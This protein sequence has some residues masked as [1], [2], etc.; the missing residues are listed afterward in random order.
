MASF[1]LGMVIFAALIVA[2]VYLF[3]IQ[4]SSIIEKWA[5]GLSNGGHFPKKADVHGLY[6]L[7]PVHRELLGVSEKI[8][9]LKKAVSEERAGRSRDEFLQ[10]CIL[11]S[12]IEGILVINGQG[13][14]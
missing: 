7:L 6:W 9:N 4:P 13:I 10:H 8:E 12:L 1:F 3:V 2:I 11:A 14:V 5:A